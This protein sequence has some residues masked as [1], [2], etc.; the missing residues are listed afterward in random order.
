MCDNMCCSRSNWLCNLVEDSGRERMKKRRQREKRKLGAIRKQKM[1]WGRLV[2]LLAASNFTEWRRCFSV[3]AFFLHLLLFFSSMA[4]RVDVWLCD[5]KN[6]IF[7]SCI[8][9]NQVYVRSLRTYHTYVQ[10]CALRI[11]EIN[12]RFRWR[13]DKAFCH[14]AISVARQ[15]RLLLPALF[16]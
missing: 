11:F 7:I 8:A 12:F 6:R 13:R 1:I 14:P 4:E 9:D 16:V 3:I 10:A 5:T 2:A 15:R